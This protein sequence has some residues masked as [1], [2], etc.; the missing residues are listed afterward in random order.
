VERT[1]PAAHM[2]ALRA[3]LHGRASRFVRAVRHGGRYTWISC[4]GDISSELVGKLDERR[5]FAAA[6]TMLAG[7]K[8]S[9]S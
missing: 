1:R 4:S 9:G 6:S 3:A 7:A 8:N 5:A 2:V